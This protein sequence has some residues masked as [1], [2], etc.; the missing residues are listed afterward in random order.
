VAT[1]GAAAAGDTV[2]RIGNRQDSAA[3]TRL[4]IAGFEAWIPYVRT[5]LSTA[6]FGVD[7]SL[8][9]T[10]LAGAYLNGS[11]KSIKESIKSMIT[12]LASRGGKPDYAVVSFDKWDQLSNELGSKVEYTDVKVGETGVVGFSGIRI[13]GPK[14]NVEVLP[15]I[16]CPDNRCFVLQRETWKLLSLGKTIGFLDED[17]NRMLREGSADQYEIRIGG[18]MELLCMAPGR[19][20]V[21]SFDGN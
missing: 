9:P 11:T 16:G 17:D 5:G 2:F 14:G 13:Q 8:H 4:R 19:N 10:R 12:T 21:I 7:R 20:G 18:Y 15:D 3:P 6:L 1:I